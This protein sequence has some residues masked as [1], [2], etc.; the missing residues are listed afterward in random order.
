M[1]FCYFVRNRSIT[2]QRQFWYYLAYKGCNRSRFTYYAEKLA[3]PRLK[4]NTIDSSLGGTNITGL[5]TFP[6]KLAH[7]YTV[8][9]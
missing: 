6:L 2:N 5:D 8:T 3:L 1:S 9:A 7:L 4:R